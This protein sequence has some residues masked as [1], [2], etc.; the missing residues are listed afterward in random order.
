[1]G[2]ALD[3]GGGLVAGVDGVAVAGEQWGGVL[4]WGG[5][6]GAGDVVVVGECAGGDQDPP[7][8]GRCRSWLC[9]VSLRS[10]RAS[11]A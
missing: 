3:W 6:V 2:G 7:G 5:G 9:S 11:H 4:R 10:A 8:L 1:L